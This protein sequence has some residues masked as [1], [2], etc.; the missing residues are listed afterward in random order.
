MQREVQS[1]WI[2]SIGPTR[3]PFTSRTLGGDLFGNLAVQYTSFRPMTTNLWME[4]IVEFI[5]FVLEHTEDIPGVC[6]DD[7]RFDGLVAKANDGFHQIRKRFIE[8]DGLKVRAVGGLQVANLNVSEP[9]RQFIDAQHILGP[10]NIAIMSQGVSFKVY[11]LNEQSYQFLLD[12][13]ND[14]GQA[15]V[16]IVPKETIHEMMGEGLLK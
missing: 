8:L 2:S 1:K 9:V 15:P 6:Q 16:C 5:D 7:I 3:L 12:M 14:G 11:L 13:T 10:V 4:R